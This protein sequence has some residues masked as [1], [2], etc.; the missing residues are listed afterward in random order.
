MPLCRDIWVVAAKH[1]SIG[2]AGVG[3]DLAGDGTHAADLLTFLS[4]RHG[5]ACPGHP[6]LALLRSWLAAGFIL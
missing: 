3:V 1:L 6:R 5:R 2:V 4:D